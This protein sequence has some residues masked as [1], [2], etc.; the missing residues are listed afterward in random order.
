MSLYAII[1]CLS[2]FLIVSFFFSPPTSDYAQESI[3]TERIKNIETQQDKLIAQKQQQKTELNQ[4]YE[5]IY[6]KIYETSENFNG[7]VGISYID[8][9][10]KKQLSF[11]GDKDFYSASTIKVALA[12]M[13]ADKVNAGELGWETVL[14]YNTTKDYETGTGIIINHIQPT[15]T[16]KTLQEYNIVYS[17]NIAKNMLYDTFGDDIQAKK[18]IYSH[19]L[20]KETDWSHAQLTSN[21]AAKILTILYDKKSDNPDYQQIYEYMKNTVFHER[22][23]T[24]KTTGKVAHKIGSYDNYIH[25]IGFLETEHPFILS[26]FTHS[27][28]DNGALFISTLTDQLWELQTN[29]YPK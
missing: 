6:Q 27:T 14:T 3:K 13:I 1:F 10:T 22:M 11:N 2:F 9:T 28:S 23:E 5:N 18:E 21:D 29:D 20:Q 16:L 8:L 12:M 25:D 7:D 26:I 19:F 4:F 17:D 15:Y 24:S